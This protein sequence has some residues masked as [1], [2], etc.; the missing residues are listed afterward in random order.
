[1]IFLILNILSIGIYSLIYWL[2]KNK[3]VK[4]YLFLA[5]TIQVCFLMC[6]RNFTVGTD[7]YTYKA[8]FLDLCDLPL[9]KLFNKS[10]YSVTYSDLEI[11]YIFLTKF[12]T[13]FTRDFNVYLYI[14]SLLTFVPTFIVFYKLSKNPVLSIFLF[15][16]I[17]FMNFYGSGIRQALS[18]TLC[19]LSLL[20]FFNK[21]KL[22]TLVLIIVAFTFHKSAIIFL[23]VFLF[24]FKWSGKNFV[25]FL[26]GFFVVFILRRMLYSAFS[27]LFGYAD[28][29][30]AIEDTGAYGM[31]LL[32]FLIVIIGFVGFG[33]NKG[34]KLYCQ[35]LTCVAISSLLM[36]F[37]LIGHNSL[38]IAF[39]FFVCSVI[40]IP[41]L[42]S[43]QNKTNLILFSSILVFFGIVYYLT[44]TM[45]LYS[46][47][48]FIFWWQS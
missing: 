5:A 26:L 33:E 16:V 3:K 4:F 47:D 40:F 32:N 6:F 2:V 20:A 48:N 14:V 41:N 37:V 34:N 12:I 1:M 39:Y 23:L 42:I 45:T 7:V 22:V 36:I 29:V 19:L 15:I 43:E 28:S 21:K 8:K 27:F 9:S 13:L 38:R 24:N 18:M 35:L 25:V 44:N 31:F 10:F 11:G 46:F 17:Q 30:Y